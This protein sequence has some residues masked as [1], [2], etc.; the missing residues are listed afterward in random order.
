MNDRSGGN[1][2]RRR[3]IGAAC[4]L[5]AALACACGGRAVTRPVTEPAAV[6]PAV[7]VEPDG[8]PAE[9]GGIYHTLQ[10]GQTLY[11]LARVYQVPLQTLMR[12]NG[13]TDP[14]DLATGAAIFIPGAT[15]ELPVPPPG[16]GELPP[17]PAAADPDVAPPP[18]RRPRVRRRAPSGPPEAGVVELAWPL[19]GRI[20]SRF[21]RRGR[22]SYHEGLDIDGVRGDRVRAAAPGTVIR[23]GVDGRYGKR[24][25]IDHGGGVTTLYA[26]A[27]RILVR[28]G[29]E[30]DRGD[31]VIE[32][33]RT[34]NARGTHLHFEV[35]R[36]GRPLDPLPLLQR[37]VVQAEAPSR[38]APDAT[39]AR[40]ARET[41]A[42][43]PDGSSGT[44]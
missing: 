4:C 37:G 2:N 40:G 29:D 39:P 19:R 30:V 32:V 13:I 31:P 9:G 6:Q 12:V 1:R 16:T 21:G 5:L 35:R 7:P 27:S 33:G 43:D 28:V 22:H 42:D 15:R 41:G 20:T 17:P 34:G 24:V 26:H 38:P 11:S 8:A 23:A 36:A 18:S 14:T 3:W 10:S 44:H 25:V